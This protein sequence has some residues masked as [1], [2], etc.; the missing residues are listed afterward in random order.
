MISRLGLWQNQ[1]S[2]RVAEDLLQTRQDRTGN[3][4]AVL[5]RIGTSGCLH[6]WT[7]L[8]AADWSLESL[9]LRVVVWRSKQMRKKRVTANTPS[10]PRVHYLINTHIPHLTSYSQMQGCSLGLDVSVL[11]RSWDVV[12]K[13]LGLISVSWECLGLV[14]DWKSNVSVSYQRVSFTSQYTQLFASLQNCR[15]IVLNARCQY[16]LLIHKLRYRLHPCCIH[17]QLQCST[18]FKK[19][20]S[21][22]LLMQNLWSR[23]QSQLSEACLRQGRV[24]TENP[25]SPDP[26]LFCTGS[27]FSWVVCKHWW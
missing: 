18:Q 4:R 9:V 1:G 17:L 8:T 23:L 25:I 2:H 3:F 26:S 15:Y 13:R 24:E 22:T 19:S 11:R 14:S 27:W 6:R 16:C 21:L 20:F 5:I 10:V 7:C 12:S